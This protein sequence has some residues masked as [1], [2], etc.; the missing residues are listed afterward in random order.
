ML[1]GETGACS[2]MIGLVRWGPAY[3][4]YLLCWNWLF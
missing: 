1:K 3:L 2:G 4:L